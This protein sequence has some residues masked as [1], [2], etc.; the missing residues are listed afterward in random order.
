MK[1]SDVVVRDNEFYGP[2]SK[3]VFLQD[4]N[5]YLFSGNTFENFMEGLETSVVSIGTSSNVV[6]SGNS[7][8][9]IVTGSGKPVFE[10]WT[11]SGLVANNNY[12]ENIQ[13][14]CFSSAYSTSGN[15]GDC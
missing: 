3:A 8:I 1:R 9:D 2:A 4:V 11:S 13:G 10:S 7:F 12:F 5:N 14:D 15:T 6:F